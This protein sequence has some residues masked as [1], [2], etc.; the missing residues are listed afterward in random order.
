MADSNYNYYQFSQNGNTEYEAN[1]DPNFKAAS[2]GSNAATISR[3]QF[4]AGTQG[5]SNYADIYNKILNNTASGVTMNNGV[6]TSDSALAQNAANQAGVANGT[7]KNIGTAAAPEYVPTGSSADK[8]SSGIANGTV[9]A[10][11]PNQQMA[12]AATGNNATSA[13]TSFPDTAVPNPATADATP[14]SG[15]ALATAQASGPAPQDAGAAR[16][17][18]QSFMP[19]PGVQAP[20]FYKPSANSQQVYDSKGNP[21]SYDQYIAAG[22]KSDFSNV[23]QGLPQNAAVDQALAGDPAYQQLLKDR[24]E[25]TSVQNQ[26]K[27]LTDTYKQISDSLGIPALDTQLM[28]MKN[29]IDGSEDDI[30]AEVTKAG[31]F[32]TNSQVLAMTDARNKVMIQN[33]NNLLQ[34]KQ[35]A[36][37][38]LTTMVGLAAQDRTYAMDSINQKLNLD[39]QMFDT[40]QKMQTN[41]A[42]AYTNV[43]DKVGYQGLLASLGN[44][45]YQVALAEQTLG[46]HPGGLQQL[47]NVGTQKIAKSETKNLGTT[48]APN[49]V[50]IGYDAAGNIVSRQS[51]SGGAAPA[52]SSSSSAAPKVSTPKVPTAASTYAQDKKGMASE[53]QAVAPDNHVSPDDWA[54]AKNAWVQAGYSAA[55]F[56]TNFSNYINQSHAQD[57]K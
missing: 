39:Q 52:S 32:A 1:V 55:S 57:Y 21:L 47:A 11:N 6:L 19:T 37:S 29:V 36:E 22:G 38:T 54:K 5:K 46:L 49:W 25:Y 13:N 30:R 53:L 35:S 17:A 14:Y 44:D 34:T 42:S 3:D 10:N 43:V 18:V 20:T 26:Q 12:A 15:A 33:Y 50:N 24:A 7:Q 16:A 40:E 23:Q 45:P 4:L 41:A 8:L 9:D 48:K 31:G 27:S 2:L 56:K 28:N 51:L